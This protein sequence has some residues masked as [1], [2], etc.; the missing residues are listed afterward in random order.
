[1]QIKSTKHCYNVTETAT[2]PA[3][4]IDKV[5]QQ[6][7]TAS[8]AIKY[9]YTNITQQHTQVMNKLYKKSNYEK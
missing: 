9:G 8:S 4:N 7:T 6:E 2:T 5:H 1:M 3:Y